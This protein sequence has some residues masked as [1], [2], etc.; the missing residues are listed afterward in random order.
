M[1]LPAWVAFILLPIFCQQGNKRLGFEGFIPLEIRI[2]TFK[3]MESHTRVVQIFQKS[4]GN[5]KILRVRKVT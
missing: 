5:P 1:N 4:R 2:V 3:F